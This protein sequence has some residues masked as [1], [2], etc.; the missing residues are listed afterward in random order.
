M[1]LIKEKFELRGEIVWNVEEG[2]DYTRECEESKKSV[3]MM[4][5]EGLFK[6]EIDIL[7]ILEFIVFETNILL[8]DVASSS[9]QPVIKY[10]TSILPFAD[11]VYYKPFVDW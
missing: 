11:P 9:D 7:Y 2:Q 4:Y 6:E 8:P 5:D 3:K 10:L 1:F